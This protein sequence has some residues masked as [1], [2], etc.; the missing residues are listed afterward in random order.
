MATLADPP[1]CLPGQQE[2]YKSLLSVPLSVFCSVVANPGNNLTFYWLFNTSEVEYEQKVNTYRCRNKRKC[3]AK[4]KLTI[5]V[6]KLI[7]FYSRVSLMM[8]NPTPMKS[9]S[10]PQNW[11][12]LGTYRVMLSIALL[13]KLV[14]VLTG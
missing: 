6:I 14:L 9:S 4:F 13:T 8:E 3:R 1:K 11:T 7:V 5:V 10:H 12:F 2:E